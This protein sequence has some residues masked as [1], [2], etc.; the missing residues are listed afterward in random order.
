MKD[1]RNSW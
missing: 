1:C